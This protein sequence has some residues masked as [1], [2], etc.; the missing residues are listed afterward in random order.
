M[1]DMGSRFTHIGFLCNKEVKEVIEKLL[2]WMDCVYWQT[3]KYFC[4]LRTDKVTEFDNFQLQ[5]RVE[6]RGIQHQFTLLYTPQS[7]GTSERMN[8]NILSRVRS[9]PI[10]TQMTKELWAEFAST[11][12]YI[13]NRL[14]VKVNEN[15][16]PFFCIYGRNPRLDCLRDFS[17]LVI[18]RN[19][20]LRGI[21]NVRA[22]ETYL[23]GYGE[24]PIIYRVY[25]PKDNSTKDTRH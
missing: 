25:D 1:V 19:M 24:V 11:V 14:P 8:Q 10:N 20:Q 21:L 12:V 2:F 18:A 22:K 23:V 7:N 17:T 3:K 13:N 9:I 16:T 6:E 15:K 5:I 4:I